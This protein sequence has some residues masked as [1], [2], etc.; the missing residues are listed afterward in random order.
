MRMLGMQA[1]TLPVSAETGFQMRREDLLAVLQEQNIA[2]LSIN[3]GTTQLGKVE[4][5]DDEIRSLC[6]EKGIWLH[7]DAAW[8]GMNLG[9]LPDRHPQTERFRRLIALQPDSI[10]FDFHKFIGRGNLSLLLLPGMQ[11][12]DAHCL[13]NSLQYMENDEGFDS[14][15]YSLSYSAA[16]ALATMSD[17]GREG[18]SNL[19]I[20]CTIAAHALAKALQGYGLQT[21]VTVNTPIV[22]VQ[23]ASDAE[24]ARVH[25]LLNAKGLRTS[26]LKNGLHGIRIVITPNM[27]FDDD[28]I[29]RLA[30]EISLAV[31]DVR[32][33]N[34]I[35]TSV[36]STRNQLVMYDM[37]GG[38][39]REDLRCR[40][41]VAPPPP[42]IGGRH[43]VQ[44][45]LKR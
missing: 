5:I 29:D 27:Y 23:L 34:A 38:M 11:E 24:A 1:S 3:A 9:C 36:E 26:C 44:R 35:K 14:S 15:K 42:Y 6:K 30:Q 45:L 19:A 43:W 22:P 7:V 16:I 33:D 12:R 39:T 20:N 41:V 8:G 21:V 37:F 4:I 28:F 40:S 32:Q 18:L 31:A 10:T 25:E 17:I 13:T 2:M